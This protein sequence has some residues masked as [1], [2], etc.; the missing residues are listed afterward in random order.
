MERQGDFHIA[1]DS[2]QIMTIS[3]EGDCADKNQSHRRRGEGYRRRCI[4]KIKCYRRRRPMKI[5]LV[6]EAMEWK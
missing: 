1:D 6:G 3:A 5:S 2:I 4:V